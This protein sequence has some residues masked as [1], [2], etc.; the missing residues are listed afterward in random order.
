MENLTVAE[1]INQE[2]STWNYQKIQQIFN[3]RDREEISK[4]PLNLL[5]TNDEQIWNC[6][7]QGVYTVRSAY[8][9]LTQVIIDSSHLRVEGHWK[10][11]APHKVKLF[12]WR[13]LRGCLP[14]RSHLVQRGV[15]CHNKCPHYDRVEENEW[16]CFFGCNTAADVWKETNERQIISNYTENAMGFVE[17]MFRLIN[18]VEPTKVARI[19]MTMWALWWRRN[20]R[21][22]ND[23][24]PTIFDVIQRA[25]NT[26][27]EWL[28]AQRQ[29]YPSSTFSACNQWRKPPTGTIKCN[30]DTACY[31]EDN[32]YCVGMCMCDEHG[33]FLQAYTIKKHGTPAIAEAE[34]LGIRE[35][36][37]W[38]QNKYG[39]ATSIEVESDCLQAVQA[40]NSR[41][42]NNTEFGS[43]IVMCRNLLFLRNNCKVSYV[44]RQANQ[45]AHSLAQA[46]HLTVGHQV[47][48]YCPPCITTTI[49]NEMK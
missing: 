12:L 49:M 9:Q 44:R 32:I 14:V 38:V 4:I 11:A 7:R 22:W 19:V 39:A 13:S 2:T 23:K 15:Q 42:A 45:V 33:R 28:R 3:A 10:L 18:E 8:Y 20:Q 43:I 1:L 48:N 41:H 46:A 17:M 6:I 37:T 47:Y 34:A 31:M 21:C 5:H 24:I 35:A 29:S 40:I 27:H 36:L 25:I 30:V 16:H 26:R